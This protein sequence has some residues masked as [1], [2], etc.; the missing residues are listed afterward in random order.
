MA[1][2]VYLSKAIKDKLDQDTYLQNALG[3]LTPDIATGESKVTIAETSPETASSV[4]FVGFT[5]GSTRPVSRGSIEGVDRSKVVFQVVTKNSL[6]TRY[7]ADRLKTTMG[8][9]PLGA[10]NS[11]FFDISNECLVCRNSTFL[12]SYDFK[13][14]RY[15]DN[16]NIFTSVVEMEFIYSTCLCSGEECDMSIPQDCEITIEDYDI[17][18]GC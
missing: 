4:P 1:N 18:F 12:D 9:K 16:E 15:N 5:I 11:W 3:S 2:T 10:T 17:D 6:K 14:N 7:I 8:Q 13:P